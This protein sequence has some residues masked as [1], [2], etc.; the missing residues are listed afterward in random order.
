MVHGIRSLDTAP[1]YGC[2]KSELDAGRALHYMT[3]LQE[4]KPFLNI[5]E[6]T[7]QASLEST[8][9]VE[10]KVRVLHAIGANAADSS[11]PDV[12]AMATKCGRVTLP[13]TLCA[14]L[15]SLSEGD[16]VDANK[17]VNADYYMSSILHCQSNYAVHPTSDQQT[18][19]HAQ[20]RA[21]VVAS[22]MQSAMQKALIAQANSAVDARQLSLGSSNDPS[23]QLDTRKVTGTVYLESDETSHLLCVHD[24]TYKG[25]LLSF[26]QSYERLFGAFHASL[27]ETITVDSEGFISIRKNKSV[28]LT[29][30]S[31]TQ[32]SDVPWFLIDTLRLHDADTDELFAEAIEP[33]V[34]GILAMRALQSRGYVRHLSL[35]SNDATFTLRY[36]RHTASETGLTS[37]T[38]ELVARSNKAA[39]TRTGP[40]GSVLLAGCWNLINA[41]PEAV[42][43]FSYMRHLGVTA[44]GPQNNVLPI[45]LHNA[46]I[47]GAGLLWGASVYRYANADDDLIQRRNA[48]SRLLDAEMEECGRVHA[49][50]K[51]AE[52][53]NLNPSRY[54]LAGAAITFA[55]SS[56][57]MP[58]N[59]GNKTP[60]TTSDVPLMPQVIRLVYGCGS[61]FE[62]S[63]TMLACA[64]KPSE[65]IVR[66]VLR[67]SNVNYNII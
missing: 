26:S 51:N 25:V 39:I 40:F 61:E 62:L 24:C 38:D 52:L 59:D 44:G 22:R 50:N 23:L 48:L 19:R 34:G 18:K 45:E 54:H 53:Y 12:I 27:D 63:E 21:N 47:F 46:G 29:S 43:L 1:W 15:G 36:L 33:T 60:N 3:I 8:N 6:V 56:T 14:S 5:A 2:G 65:D 41:E 42:S 32:K 7:L 10:R 30:S 16:A 11:S 31:T 4:A 55:S 20:L 13:K 67:K 66:T 49:D 58:F 64:C 35:G 37:P 9:S 57:G 17:N 28:T